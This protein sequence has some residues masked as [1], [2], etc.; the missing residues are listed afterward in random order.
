MAEFDII[1][2]HFANWQSENA[3]VVLGIGDDAAV[4]EV[5]DEHQL[6]VTTDLF[7]PGIHFPENTSAEDIAYKAL[8]VNLSDLAA[9][10]AKPGWF[11]LS[12]S[13]PKIDNNWLEKFSHSL[14][15]TAR[16]YNIALVGGDTNQGPLTIN[17]QA[18]GQVPKNQALRRDGA[19]P[20]DCIYCT[21]TLG[22]A[23]LGLA[24]L[25]GKH[26]VLDEEDRIYFH[27]RLNRPMPRVGAGL[28]LR[29]GASAAIDIS[30]GLVADLSHL[31]KASG[32]LG[33]LIHLE[34]IPLS[35]P[36][37][38]H[39]NEIEAWETA[40]SG[41]DDYELC[42]TVSEKK[43]GILETSLS[44]AGCSFV[45]IGRVTKKSGIQF[46]NSGA[47]LSL[48]LKGFEHFYSPT[49]ITDIK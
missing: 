32:E 12:L 25:Q 30:D 24:L 7:L 42:F 49:K 13:I 14:A 16:F 8:A 39:M 40:L 45:C 21:G 18:M 38:R 36:L 3:S 47:N 20:G 27:E 17:I 37:K 9:M 4:I 41:G 44:N 29:H 1:Q 34:D 5:P 15:E 26:S 33:A 6:V 19:K 31:L 46:Q 10:S 22:D 28:S 23:A 48:N 11:T 35:E 43:R 2:Q